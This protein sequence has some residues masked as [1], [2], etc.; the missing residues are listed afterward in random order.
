MLLHTKSYDPLAHCA[1]EY[2]CVYR[3]C[4]IYLCQHFCHMLKLPHI[5]VMV[6]PSI[7]PKSTLIA[8]IMESI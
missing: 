8:Y 1:L 7:V 6:F 4:L 3:Y 2:I 5:C